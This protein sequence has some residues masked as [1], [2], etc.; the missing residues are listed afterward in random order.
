MLQEVD[1]VASTGPNIVHTVRSA[2]DRVTLNIVTSL[3]QSKG[4]LPCFTQPASL[5]TYRRR[6]MKKCG[7]QQDSAEQIRKKLPY[8]PAVQNNFMVLVSVEN[9]GV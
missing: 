4:R 8:D 6:Q 1:R 5:I 9:K 3:L 7:R 2:Q